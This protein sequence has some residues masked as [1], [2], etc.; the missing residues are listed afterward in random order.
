MKRSPGDLP[1]F[2]HPGVFVSD[3]IPSNITHLNRPVVAPQY[4]AGR[5][6]RPAKKPFV[7]KGHDRDLEHAQMNATPV[8]LRLMNSDDVRGVI[9]RR[10]KFTVTLRHD[11][12]EFMGLEGI[13]YKHGIESVIL[14]KG[15]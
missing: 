11:E 6:Q 13:Y 12:G 5:V 14:H 15:S 8:T 2:H 10:D 1:D 7:A 3:T 4:E 9:V